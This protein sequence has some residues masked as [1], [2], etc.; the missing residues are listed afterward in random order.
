MKTFLLLLYLSGSLFAAPFTGTV[1]CKAQNHS[2]EMLS[3]GKMLLIRQA[4]EGFKRASNLIDL[5]TGSFTQIQHHNHSYTILGKLEDW[6]KLGERPASPAP[7]AAAVPELKATEETKDILGHKAQKYSLE[8]HGETLEIWATNEGELPPFYAWQP[9]CPEPHPAYQIE[10]QFPALLRAKNIFPLLV[11]LKHGEQS[12]PLL[13]VTS[14]TP[15]GKDD[16][17]LDEKTYTIPADHRLQEH[18]Q[19]MQK[20]LRQ[21]HENQPTDNSK[22]QK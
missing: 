17:S 16:P 4:G 12:Q 22:Q 5:K 21:E 6:P 11:T 15:A 8:S 14:I 7:P 2:L 19:Q 1:Q 9:F 13:E 20:R 18:P 10:E 3:D